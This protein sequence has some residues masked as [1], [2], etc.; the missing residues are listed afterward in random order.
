MSIGD[1]TWRG[2]LDGFHGLK[3]MAAFGRSRRD[4]GLRSGE[5]ESLRPAAGEGVA[6]G[7]RSAPRPAFGWSRRDCQWPHRPGASSR[8]P[9]TPN[10]RRQ[11]LTGIFIKLH[12]TKSNHRN[13]EGSS[14]S[15]NRTPVRLKRGRWEGYALGVRG[16]DRALELDDLSP[17]SKILAAIFGRQDGIDRAPSF[18]GGGKRAKFF[19]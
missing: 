17:H 14:Q 11:T 13:Y 4:W 10:P 9:Q 6:T 18:T 12:P 8:L 2:G 16:H 5:K 1:A 19:A 3:S 15:Q 7:R